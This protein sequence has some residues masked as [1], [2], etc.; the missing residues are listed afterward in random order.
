MANYPD[1]RRLH[2]D[3]CKSANYIIKVINKSDKDD[4]SED[5]YN[6][7]L[8]IESYLSDIESDVSTLYD[9]VQDMES[10]IDTMTDNILSKQEASQKLLCHF[11]ISKFVYMNYDVYKDFE[12]KVINNIDLDNNPLSILGIEMIGYDFDIEN[13]I[14]RIVDEKQWAVTKIKY[15]I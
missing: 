3:I 8:E 11:D 2:N 1:T 14:F 4:A 9:V 12:T 7:L 5:L 6:N 10:E 13:Y 15:G